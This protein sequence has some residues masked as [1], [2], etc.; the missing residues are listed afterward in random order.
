MRILLCV[1][2]VLV[3]AALLACGAT[4]DQLRAR[5][6]F[7]L[8]CPESKVHII[9]IDDRTRGVR[10]CGQQATYVEACDGPKGSAAT[11]CTWV[12]NTDSTRIRSESE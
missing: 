7:D 2:F 5:A 4:E 10:A 9:T 12:L 11:S 8:D 6:A 1:P 3:L